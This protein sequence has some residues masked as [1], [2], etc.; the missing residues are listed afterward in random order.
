MEMIILEGH[1]DLIF[2]ETISDKIF[3]IS[4][5]L[6]YSDKKGYVNMMGSILNEN[7]YQYLKENFGFI[8]YGDNGKTTV[9]SKIIPRFTYD[10]IRKIP[11]KLTVFTILDE[12]GTPLDYTIKQI[13]KNIKYRNIPHVNIS[14]ERV[15][16]ISSDIDDSYAIEFNLYLI[17]QS[18]E[19][20]LVAASLEHI[21]IKQI[22]KE[23]L[24]HEDPHKALN[25]L[26]MILGIS[27]D[28][29]IRKSIREGWFNDSPWFTELIDNLE[30]ILQIE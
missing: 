24:M 18:L 2:I 9:V 26:A 13:C 6:R 3:N 4:K 25:Q 28:D 27:K 5:F 17:P 10:V 20:N 22:Q 23:K 11:E 21:K 1:N 14:C 8:I 15:I 12:D 19:K 16:Y 30:K 7:K 29:L